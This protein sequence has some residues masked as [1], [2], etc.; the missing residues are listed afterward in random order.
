MVETG[1]RRPIAVL[2]DA[3][4]FN[5]ELS[6][7]RKQLAFVSHQDGKDNLWTVSASGG[8]PKK[9]TNNNDSRLYFSSLSWAGD[10]SRIYY[11]KQ[12][13]YSLLSMLNDFK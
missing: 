5:I 2:K 12:M 3:Y 7:D 11:G 10:S 1:E 6:A 9:I 13:R 8:K 4:L